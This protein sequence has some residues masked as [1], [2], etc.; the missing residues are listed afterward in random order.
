LPCY[1]CFSF[2][3]EWLALTLRRVNGSAIDP[4]GLQKGLLLMLYVYD[5]G[6]R[7]A[8]SASVTIQGHKFA[9]RYWYDGD[10]I[11]NAKEDAAEVALIWL[12][13]NVPIFATCPSQFFPQQ[14]GYVRPGF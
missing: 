10:Y 2:I 7:T 4:A 12:K 1:F 14:N 11:D 3:G 9:A 13:T 6:G 8:W 5:A